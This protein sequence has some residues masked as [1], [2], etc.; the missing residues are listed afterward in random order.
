MVMTS[1]MWLADRIPAMAEIR[2]LT[3]VLREAAGRSRPAW[4]RSRRRWPRRSTDDEGRNES[5]AERG[6]QPQGH[7][8]L[9]TTTFEGV[10]SKEQ[11]AQ[12]RSGA[13]SVAAASRMLAGNDEKPKSV[14]AF[15]HLTAT[16]R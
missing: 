8:T 10:K 13:A 1:D 3:A 11:M 9:S 6:R 16:A 15:D 14:R 5:H 7:A 4:T 12:R 2:E